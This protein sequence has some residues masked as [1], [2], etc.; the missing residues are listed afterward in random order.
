MPLLSPLLSN[1]SADHGDQDVCAGQG[2]LV[3]VQGAAPP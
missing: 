2:T 1:V 3:R